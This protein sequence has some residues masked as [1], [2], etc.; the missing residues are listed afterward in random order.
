MSRASSRVSLR[1]RVELQQETASLAPRYDLAQRSKVLTLCNLSLPDVPSDVW[2]LASLVRLDLGGNCITELSDCVR[3]LTCLE[4]LWLNDNPLRALPPEIEFCRRLKVLDLRATRLEDVP[5]SLGR[6]KCLVELDVTRTP[7]AATVASVYVTPL[8]TLALMD[9]L[10]VEDQRTALRDTMLDQCLAGVYRESADVREHRE[11]I[12]GLVDAVCGEFPDLGDLRNVVR[13]CDR[14]LPADVRAARDA[15]GAARRVREQFTAMRRDN[16]KKRLSADL[17]LKMR[18]L[19]Y[20]RIDPQHVEG[21]IRA[22]YVAG[23]SER[24]LE[25]EDVQFLIKYAAQVLPQDPRAITGAGVRSAVWA[26]Q[27]SLADERAACIADVSAALYALYADIEPPLVSAL[28]H[29]AC[30]LFQRDRFA[31]KR[32]LGELKKLAA[33]AGQLF[34]AEFQNAKPEKIKDAFRLREKQA[35]TPQVS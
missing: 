31:T 1:R 7:Y 11:A 17:E 28:A 19:Y 34:P 24:P 10:G 32:E 23:P 5:M 27:R 26:L 13:N 8:D 20:D 4:Q 33:D 21:Y 29:A 22:I 16:D 25:L 14:L 30:L 2:S 15:H 3:D 9:L 18:A 6:L 12:A 35:G